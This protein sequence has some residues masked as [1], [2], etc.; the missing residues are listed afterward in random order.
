MATFVSCSVVEIV[1]PTLYRANFICIELVMLV[2]L[3]R[4]CIHL[5]ASQLAKLHYYFLQRKFLKN[6]TDS[7]EF[8]SAT[9]DTV[10][11]AAENFEDFLSSS[12]D[13]V[14]ILFKY[15]DNFTEEAISYLQPEATEV[16]SNCVQGLP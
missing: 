2:V 6:I 11:C 16:Y 5:P 9:A 4:I 7:D 13:Y 1:Y 15:F 3:P 14:D 10:V 8:D 12:L